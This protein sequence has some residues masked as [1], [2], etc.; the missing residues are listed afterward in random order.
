MLIPCQFSASSNFTIVNEKGYG[1]GRTL[2]SALHACRCADMK[3]AH[4]LGLNSDK[5]LGSRIKVG[6]GFSFLV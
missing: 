5:E 2:F 3:N 1:F 4:K 6:K